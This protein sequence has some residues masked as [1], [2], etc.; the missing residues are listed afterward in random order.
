M[1]GSESG[2]IEFR[3]FGPVEAARSENVLPVGGKRQQALVALLLLDPGRPFAAEWLAEELWQG[4]PPPGAQVTLR[5]YV[6]RLRSALG[7]PISSGPAGYALVV[8]PEQ[9]DA[10]RFERL[11]R[12]G[13]EAL[14][15]GAPRRAA[16][17][18]KVALDLWRGQPFADLGG[19]GALRVEADRLEELRLLALE[20]LMDAELQLGG[21]AELV[22]GLEALVGEHPYRERLWQHLMLAL[23]RSQRQAEALEAYQRAYKVLGKE[24]GLEP[25]EKL[26]ALEQAILRHEVEPATPPE[27][28]HN[29]PAPLTN[30]IG[31]E[32]ELGEI[33]SLLEETRLLTLTGVGGVGKTRLALEA[34]RRALPASPDGVYFVDLSAI[35]DPALVHRHV[36]GALDVGDQGDSGLEDALTARLR[37]A[38]LLLVLDNCEHLRGA[39]AELIQRL[40]SACSR[41]RVLATSRESLGATGEVDYAVPPLAAPEAVDLFLIRARAV[42]PRLTDDDRA[43]QA[44]A[45]ICADLDELPLAIEL[46]AARAKALSLEDIAAGLADRFRFLVSWRRLTPTR[47]RTLREAMDWSYELLS[48]EEQ[49]FFANL[50][51]FAGGFTLDACARVCLDGDQQRS[52]ELIERLVDASLVTLDERRNRMRY[53]QLE[54]VRQYAAERLQEDPCAAAETSRAHSRF[55]VEMLGDGDAG[56]PYGAQGAVLDDDLENLRAAIDNAVARAD[57]ETELGLIGGIWRYWWVRG[58]LDEGRARI[59]SALERADG[60][61]GLAVVR[62]LLGAAGLAFAQ[63]AYEPARAFAERAFTEARAAG[64]A[65]HEAVALNTLGVTAMRQHDYDLAR[66]SLEKSVTLE[67]Q[68][69]GDPLAAKLNLGV[70]ELEA[71]RPEAAVPIFED[72]RARHRENGNTH[73]VGWPSLNLGIAVFRL[74]EYER[75]GAYWEE[76]RAAFEAVGFPA[77]VGRAVLGLAAVESRIGAPERAARLLGHADALLGELGVAE[78]DFMPELALTVESTLRSQL[79][80]HEFSAAREEGFSSARPSA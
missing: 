12:D 29:L 48:K 23:Y 24:L 8:A 61:S 19:E 7:V 49:R 50:S 15:R 13:R 68:L 39:C 36:A 20:D 31:R 62:V 60:L 18:L 28:R 17:R 65:T 45:T 27:E 1:S 22:D 37:D 58:Y 9:V 74:G 26:K 43:R 4:V 77:N 57:I 52:H 56:A 71:G 59:A 16:E 51:I 69:G 41:L 53:R 38:E 80:D 55:F 10:V 6:S 47:H 64:S 34:G 63:G 14:A 79:G 25:S 35:A 5:S 54:T 72:V 75:A 3:L 2:A 33:T 73:G 46:A 32:V 66:R 76:A 44:A 11:M 67:E 21:G 70:V 40:L 78:D 42:R 30:F